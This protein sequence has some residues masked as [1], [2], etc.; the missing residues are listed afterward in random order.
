MFS[1]Y[2]HFFCGKNSP[3]S[4][5]KTMHDNMDSAIFGNPQKNCH[6]FSKNVWGSLRFAENLK[7][8]VAYLF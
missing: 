5:K 4:K 2:Q 1:H 6:I 3:L 8:F 7:I